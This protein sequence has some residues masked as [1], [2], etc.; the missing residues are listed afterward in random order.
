MKQF[1]MHSKFLP[2]ETQIFGGKD[3]TCICLKVKGLFDEKGIKSLTHFF[4]V[5][6]F[7]TPK[8]IRKP[9]P[10]WSFHRV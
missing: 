8:N 3:Q 5:V 9:D 4:P 6:S 7:P 10:F 2:Y 1:L